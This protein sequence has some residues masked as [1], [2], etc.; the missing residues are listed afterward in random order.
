MKLYLLGILASC[1]WAHAN[2]CTPQNPP[3]DLFQMDTVPLPLIEASRL[4]ALPLHCL[5]TE[6]PNKL[7]QVL[8][9]SDEIDVPSV[10][11]PAFYGCFDWH[12]AVHGHWMLVALLRRFPE[13]P[14]AVQITDQ[15]QESIT[16][17][18]IQGELDY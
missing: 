8:G 6:Y 4:A 13:F 2:V 16:D 17:A 15:L 18:H 7:N 11:H 5:K 9:T 14:E 1:Q 3:S 10:L 12:S